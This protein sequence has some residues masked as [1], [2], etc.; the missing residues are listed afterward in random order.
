MDK[1]I[2]FAIQQNPCLVNTIIIIGLVILI[3]GLPIVAIVWL[4]KYLNKDR[5]IFANSNHDLYRL[6]TV[7]GTIHKSRG[8]IFQQVE[9]T[10]PYVSPSANTTDSQ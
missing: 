9:I 7:K 1:L 10:G 5:Y 3:I 4:I 2:E 8:L 6:D